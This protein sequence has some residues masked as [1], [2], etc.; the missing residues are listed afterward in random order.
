MWLV[1]SFKLRAAFN[2]YYFIRFYYLKINLCY[3]IVM[4]KVNKT[5]IKYIPNYLDYLE[6]DQGLA[7]KSIENYDRFLKKF[8]GWLDKNGL[9]NI[10]PHQLTAEHIYKYKTFLSHSSPVLKK[11]T[12]NYYLISL[13]N[14]LKYFAEK[15]ITTLPADKIKLLRDKD[16]RQIKFLKLEQIEKLLLSPAL[17]SES[18]LRDRAILETLFSAGLRVAELVALD[19][20]QLK[21]TDKTDFLEVVIKGKGGR[22]RTVYFSPR[23]IEALRK[24]LN[25]RT[26]MDKA[27]FI[28]YSKKDAQNK[29]RRLTVRSVENIVK[30]YVK[31]AGL[32]V[33]TS[34]H[35]IRHSYAT[36]LLGSGVDLRLVQEFLGHRNITTTQIYTHITNKQLKDVHQKYHGGSKIRK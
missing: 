24:Y 10:K 34:P 35:S 36:D 5:I 16:D 20:D 2:Y 14:L 18:G 31:I 30:K 19:R 12:Q 1:N 3:N 8:V 15:D 25:K 27:L 17:D 11:N 6:I 7:P 13:R 28:N 23:A 29:S 33:M 21:I 9:S 4:N 26:D 32:P 22:I